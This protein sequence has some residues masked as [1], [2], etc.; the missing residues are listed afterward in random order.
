MLYIIP[1]ILLCCLLDF[2]VELQ[3]GATAFF[4]RFHSRG[5]STA[6]IL[7]LHV[8][9]F[10]ALEFS[11][12]GYFTVTRIFTDSLFCFIPII[13]YLHIPVLSFFNCTFI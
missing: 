10:G 8:Q 3:G 11:K 6:Q 7:I 2:S 9:E 5:V 4:L 1:F 13:C 12:D